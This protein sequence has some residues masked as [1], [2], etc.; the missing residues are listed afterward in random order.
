MAPQS[1]GGEELKKTNHKT[2]QSWFPNTQKIH[3]ML[4]CSHSSSKMICR[5][6]GGAPLAL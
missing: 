1:R 5:T 6:E 3:F 2:L 4:L